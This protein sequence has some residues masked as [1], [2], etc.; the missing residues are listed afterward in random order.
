VAARTDKLVKSS[1]N[2]CDTGEAD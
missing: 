2:C 1:K